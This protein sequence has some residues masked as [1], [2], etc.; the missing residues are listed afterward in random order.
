MYCE[1]V[2]ARARSTKEFCEIADVVISPSYRK[3]AASAGVLT[4]D[5]A[6]GEIRNVGYRS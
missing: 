2:L 4:R 6:A 1:N 5:L 3:L